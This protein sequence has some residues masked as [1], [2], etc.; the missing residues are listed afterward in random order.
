MWWGWGDHGLGEIM[1]WLENVGTAIDPQMAGE[2][3]DLSHH[4]PSHVFAKTM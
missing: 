3:D 4:I 2:F 1:G